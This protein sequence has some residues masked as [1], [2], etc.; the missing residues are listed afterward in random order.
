MPGLDDVPVDMRAERSF[1]R[2]PPPLVPIIRIPT[3]RRP[4]VVDDRPDRG[5]D[6]YPGLDRDFPGPTDPEVFNRPQR[7]PTPAVQPVYEIPISLAAVDAALTPTTTSMID[8]VLAVINRESAENDMSTGSSP[9][10]AAIALPDTTQ[11]PPAYSNV[12]TNTP[13]TQTSGE[14]EYVEMSSTYAE[15]GSSRNSSQQAS[16]LDPNRHR[17]SLREP[18]TSY[19]DM[20]E[21]EGLQH[22]IGERGIPI[23]QG[24]PP[25]TRPP[26]PLPVPV[27]YR[28]YADP[29]ARPAYKLICH[30][31]WFVQVDGSLTLCAECAT[32]EHTFCIFNRINAVWRQLHLIS[33]TFVHTDLHCGRCYAILMK[34]RRAIDCFACRSTIIDLR[35]RTEHLT[36]KILCEAVIPRGGL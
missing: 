20:R 13:A 17:P 24:S 36:Y 25:P 12:P 10:E 18:S 14:P 22:V 31:A 26:V 4:P 19:D 30:S 16:P 3:T 8:E 7:P 32:S 1:R 9:Q 6:V 28:D 29:Y 15:A 23:P 2:S 27:Y 35:G 33:R 34:T 21:P 11:P 5:I